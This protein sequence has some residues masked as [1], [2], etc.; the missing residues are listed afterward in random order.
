LALLIIAVNLMSAFKSQADQTETASNP[1]SLKSQEY[2]QSD[3][4]IDEYEP[5]HH[6]EHG[7][8]D[9]D[10]ESIHVISTRLGRSVN[11]ERLFYS[12]KSRQT[13]W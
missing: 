1:N 11:D 13:F 9:D 6:D 10:V 7:H 2:A 5:K 12:A 3:K 8:D 4:S